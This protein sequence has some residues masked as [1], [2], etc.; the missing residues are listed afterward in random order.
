MTR[1]DFT[2]DEEYEEA[3]EYYKMLEEEEFYKKEYWLNLQGKENE[4]QK[5]KQGTTD[6][7]KL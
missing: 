2:S 7:Q 1:Y 6:E 3:V 4:A 5:Q